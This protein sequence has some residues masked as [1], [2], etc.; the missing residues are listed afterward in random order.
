MRLKLFS[1]PSLLF[2]PC[3]L[4]LGLLL[5]H[6]YSEKYFLM[7]FQASAYSFGHGVQSEAA[8]SHQITMPISYD[9]YFLPIMCARWHVQIK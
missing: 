7:S 4:L 5:P 3:F 9:K 2:D 1:Y 8:K 6:F